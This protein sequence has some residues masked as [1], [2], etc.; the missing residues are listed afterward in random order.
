MLT[1]SNGKAASLSEQEILKW[2]LYVFWL[3]L[4][5]LEDK[6]LKRSFWNRIFDYF[7]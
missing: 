6:A 1:L 2:Y 7:N 5:D 4:R 3:E